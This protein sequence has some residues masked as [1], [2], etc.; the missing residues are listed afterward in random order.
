MQINT[1]AFISKA[2]IIVRYG[3]QCECMLKPLREYKRACLG[4]LNS[5]FPVRWHNQL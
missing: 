3:L 2:E 5:A 4:Q 1:S